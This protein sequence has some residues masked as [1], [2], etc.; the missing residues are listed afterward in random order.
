MGAVFRADGLPPGSHLDYW[1]GVVSDVFMPIDLRGEFGPQAP[2]E[3]RTAELGPIRLND[4]ATAAPFQ[5]VRTSRLIRRSTPDVFLVGV[6]VAGEQRLE[7]DDRQAALRAGDLSFVDP[8]RP[9]KR[10]FSAMRTLTVSIPRAMLPLRDPDLAE[11]TGIRIPGDRGS[12]AVASLLTQSVASR[13]GQMRASEA[14]RLG[15]VLAD[16]MTVALAGH[17]DRA[18]A[19]PDPRE[20]TLRRHV[21]VFIEQHLA[22]PGLAPPGIAAAHHISLRSLHKLFETEPVTVADWIRRRRLQRCCQ[23]LV[24]PTMSDRPVAAIAARWGLPNPAH[25]NRAFR[26]AYGLPPAE[27]RIRAVTPGTCTDLTSSSQSRHPG[28]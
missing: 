26:A 10:S 2:A 4:S 16:T 11:L 17:L 19:V 6:L 12:G 8:A 7:Q 27:F 20:R 25:F 9:S 13:V 28:E 15:A 21:Y 14:A 22:D 18:S 24:D 3:M 23:D 1:R 5:T